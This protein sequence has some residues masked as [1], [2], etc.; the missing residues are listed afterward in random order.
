[1]LLNTAVVRR[2][3]ALA[4][5]ERYRA[6]LGRHLREVSD[7]IIEAEYRDVEAQPEE[8]AP[9]LAPSDRGGQ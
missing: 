4:Q 7:K 1:M 5:L 8:V 3:D 9:S 2:D 6:G